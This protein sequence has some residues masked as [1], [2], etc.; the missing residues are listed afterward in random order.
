MTGLI[1]DKEF[2]IN[3]SPVGVDLIQLPVRPIRQELPF[4]RDNYETNL[5][6]IF[7]FCLTSPAFLGTY[8]QQHAS[9]L[10]APF[11]IGLHDRLYNL[12]ATHRCWLSKLQL[13]CAR[14]YYLLLE[15]S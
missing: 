14:A 2:I 5:H 13:K 6:T 11:R 1:V 7:S 8:L 10:Q 15:I 9:L 4:L 3:Q 12:A